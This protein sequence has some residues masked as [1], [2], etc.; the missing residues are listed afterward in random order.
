MNYNE[1]KSHPDIE[2]LRDEA[3]RTIE[4]IEQDG[5]TPY[6]GMWTMVL[7]DKNEEKLDEYA[8]AVKKRFRDIPTK[9][10][11]ASCRERVS[12]PV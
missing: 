4:Y 2:E 12:S 11:R 8:G 3:T 1:R 7:F 9:I 6:S 10:G 5:Q